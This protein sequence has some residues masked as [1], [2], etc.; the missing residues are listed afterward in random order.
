MFI[1][2]FHVYTPDFRKEIIGETRRTAQVL[3]II[4]YMTNMRGPE[5]VRIFNTDY[6]SKKEI[7]R[8]LNP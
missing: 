8:T 2:F 7:S 3:I 6:M 5:K 4:I 1:M